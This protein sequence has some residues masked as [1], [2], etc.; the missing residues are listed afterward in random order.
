MTKEELK[1]YQKEYQ[2]NW[3]QKNKEEILL[4]C[5]EYYENNKEKKV[6]QMR[7]Y[8]KNNREK[9]NKTKSHYKKEKRQTDPLFKLTENIRC[10]VNDSIKNKG[11]KK[12]TKTELI[13]GCSFQEFKSHLESKFESWMSWDN[14]G[15][16]KDDIFELNKTWDIDHIIPVSS[17]NTKEEL[18]KLNHYTNLQPLCSKINRHI[19]KD[20]LDFI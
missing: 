10:L 17:A 8:H 16:P 14:H 5:K 3:Y 6:L 20:I 12:L 1:E 11:Y 4:K 2:K 13:L 19:K 18:I 7:E 9:I 15:N